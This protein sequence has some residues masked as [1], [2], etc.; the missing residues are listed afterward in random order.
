MTGFEDRLVET[1]ETT[2]KGVLE[3]AAGEVL[4]KQTDD[5][6][7]EE[8]GCTVAKDF[9]AEEKTA[10]DDEEAGLPEDE[11]EGCEAGDPP[12]EASEE[13]GEF[14]SAAKAVDC[15]GASFDLG[16]DPG[17]EEHSQQGDGLSDQH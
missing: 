17:D 14:A 6:K 8:P 9:A 12:G 2:G 5:E 11:D 10:V 15:D 7:A 3:I 4:F 13:A 1:G 16:H